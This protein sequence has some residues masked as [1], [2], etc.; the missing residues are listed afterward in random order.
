MRLESQSSF[1][2]KGTF[3]SKTKIQEIEWI[4]TDQFSRVNN[5]WRH[6]QRFNIKV[7]VPVSNEKNNEFQQMFYQA[8]E[9]DTDMAEILML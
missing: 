8:S 7:Q 2:K 5:I 4:K 6:M 1:D 9:L 3:S